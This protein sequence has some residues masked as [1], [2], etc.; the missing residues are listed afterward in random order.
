MVGLNVQLLIAEAAVIR[1]RTHHERVGHR[2]EF[3][4]RSVPI[5]HARR[6][7]LG[8]FGNGRLGNRGIV[9]IGR[10]NI[11]ERSFGLGRVVGQAIGRGQL[12]WILVIDGDL[13]FAE[14][15]FVPGLERI[16]ANLLPVDTGAA[17][18]LGSGP[19]RPLS[20]IL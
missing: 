4:N 20:L 6:G 5:G 13:E 3:E 12:G 7:A 14:A 15:D 9:Q 8:G 11:A 2:V 10:F 18:T 1:D 19:T 16:G 17:A